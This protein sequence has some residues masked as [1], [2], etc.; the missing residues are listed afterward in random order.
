MKSV[1]SIVK[2][3]EDDGHTIS[4]FRDLAEYGVNYFSSLYKEDD[5]AYVA[6][7]ARMTSY[8]PSFCGGGE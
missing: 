4:G 3:Q 7:M 5:K 1:N 2:L 8:F 6:K